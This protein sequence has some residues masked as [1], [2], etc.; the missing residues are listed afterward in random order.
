MTGVGLLTFDED[1]RDYLPARHRTGHLRH[2]MLALEKP[3]ANPRAAMMQR[4]GR[5]QPASW[6]SREA[7]GVPAEGN[8]PERAPAIRHA[9]HRKAGQALWP[10]R[11]GYVQ[12]IQERETA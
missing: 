10:C 5:C 1:L 2:L 7:L 4:G 6:R 12:G 8:P 11:L 3:A 9:G